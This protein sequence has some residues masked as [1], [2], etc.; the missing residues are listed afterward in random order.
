MEVWCLTVLVQFDS[1]TSL[2]E[3]AAGRDGPGEIDSVAVWSRSGRAG[4]GGGAG[5][6]DLTHWL[7]GDIFGEHPPGITP[8]RYVAAL[9]ELAAG[10]LEQAS[11][12]EAAP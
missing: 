5:Q 9:V 11:R 2:G 4:A 1:G 8:D 10:L 7:L 3:E 12:E 6:R